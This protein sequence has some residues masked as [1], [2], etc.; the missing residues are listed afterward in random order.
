MVIYTIIMGFLLLCFTLVMIF[1]SRIDVTD[2]GK[3][4][5]HYT[6][7]RKRCYKILFKI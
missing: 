3:V 5:L 1:E 2:D 4:I 6:W 7:K